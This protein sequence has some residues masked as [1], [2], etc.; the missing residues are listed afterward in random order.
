MIQSRRFVL[1]LFVLTVWSRNAQGQSEN[2][3]QP[4]PPAVEKSAAAAEK[5]DIT[6]SGEDGAAAGG[7]EAKS[8]SQ[9]LEQEVAALKSKVDWMEQ[10]YNEKIAAAEKEYEDKLDEM[11]AEALLA[12]SSAKIN[13][14]LHLYGFYDMEL[15]WRH[16]GKKFT[17]GN[18]ENAN[19]PLQFFN[20][21]FNLYLASQ[22]TDTVSFLGEVRFTFMPNGA[23]SSQ[24]VGD[25]SRTSTTYTDPYTQN[26]ITLGGVKIER[27][28]ITWS[29]FEFL[30]VNAGYFITPYGIWHEDHGSPVRLSILPPFENNTVTPREV[31]GVFPLPDAQLGLMFFGQVMPGDYISLNYALTVSNGRGPADTVIDY[32]DN[33]GLGLRLKLSYKRPNV[34][35][36]AG[37]YGYFGEYTDRQKGSASGGESDSG[38]MGSGYYVAEQYKEYAVSADLLFLF[39]GV[40]LQ[41]EYIAH[42][43]RYTDEGRPTDAMN[44]ATF[45]PDYAGNYVY[46]LLGYQL[47]LERWLKAMTLTPY[48]GAEFDMPKDY[49]DALKNFVIWF[50]LNF[51]PCPAVSLKV[52]GVRNHMEFGFGGSP[53]EGISNDEGASTALNGA[54][55]PS[56]GEPLSGGTMEGDVWTLAFQLAVSF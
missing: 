22:M 25:W 11:R 31:M 8:S 38:G 15:M 6:A 46:G 55:P 23:E 24:M 53:S 42:R 33:K 36:S 44:N 7:A 39:Y 10:D 28:G 18:K 45:V 54:L 21:N 13:K 4:Q 40:R 34:E 32:D 48:F 17:L 29:P 43:V 14:L 52:E 27:V 26:D 20:Q 12:E 19:S 35:I 1:I 56:G 5:R 3:A 50:G 30:G 9:D 47:P 2:G 51:S 37:G 41:A 49:M 16:I